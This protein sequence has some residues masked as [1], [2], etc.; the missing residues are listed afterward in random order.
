M[1]AFIVLIHVLYQIF[2]IC[3][4]FKTRTPK[5]ETLP[6]LDYFRLNGYIPTQ[7][8]EKLPANISIMKALSEIGRSLVLCTVL[9]AIIM[10]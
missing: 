8:I 5:A 10:N 3:L 4:I 1:R 2:Y 9:F 6:G 7:Q